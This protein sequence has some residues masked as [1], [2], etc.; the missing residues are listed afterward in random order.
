M[1]EFQ[2]PYIEGQV[3]DPADA[4]PRLG[5]ELDRRLGDIVGRLPQRGEPPAPVP[6][7]SPEPPPARPSGIWDQLT[8][9]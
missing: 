3:I 8:S 2:S 5:G 9:V 4:E 1:N 7:A 6:P